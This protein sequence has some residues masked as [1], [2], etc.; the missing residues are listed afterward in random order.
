LSDTILTEPVSNNNV[1]EIKLG[2][3]ATAKN[4]K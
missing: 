3:I 4:V 2:K 1:Q